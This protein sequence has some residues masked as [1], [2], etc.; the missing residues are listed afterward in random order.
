MFLTLM[1]VEELNVKLKTNINMK[2]GINKVTLVG[3]VGDEPKVNN[4]N[5]TTKV[6]RFPLLILA[7]VR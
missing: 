2:K 4:I 7:L 1:F 3:H 5:D 6:A